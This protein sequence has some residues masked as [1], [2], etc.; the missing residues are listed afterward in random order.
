MEEMA[1]PQVDDNYNYLPFFYVA[2]E[3]GLQRTDIHE[4]AAFIWPKFLQERFGAGILRALWSNCRTTTS[5]TAWGM[6]IDSAGSTIEKEFARFALWNYYTGNRNIAGRFVSGADYPQVNI[7]QHI[8][9]LPDSGNSSTLPPEPYAAN[10]IVVENLNGYDGMLTFDFTGLTATVWG[11]SYIIDYGG[12]VYA[13]SVISP[14]VNGKVKISIPH[15]ENALR[16]TFIPA[17]CSHFGTNFNYTY[18]LYFRTPGDVDL[19]GR[20]SISDAVYLIN[21]IFSGGATPNPVQAADLNCDGHGSVSD[22]VY[23]I[24]YIFAGGAAPCEL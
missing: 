9:T 24:R 2:T 3:Q 22:V 16:V 12:G 1:F 13:D 21:W 6:A 7:M 18:H 17:V 10:Y 4:Y 5:V 19:D 20:L 23:L 14:L 8:Y 15:F 11:V